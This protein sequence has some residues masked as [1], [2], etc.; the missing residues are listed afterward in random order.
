M[1]VLL[2]QIF[3][4]IFPSEE[5]GMYPPYGAGPASKKKYKLLYQEHRNIR[6][7]SKCSHNSLEIQFS[8]TEHIYITLYILYIRFSHCISAIFVNVLITRSWE[9]GFFITFVFLW[10]TTISPRNA[11]L[12]SSRRCKMVKAYSVV[13]FSLQILLNML[14]D[15]WCAETSFPMK[16]I[17][18]CHLVSTNFVTCSENVQSIF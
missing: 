10:P 5:K 15:S 8:E 13:N 18:Y 12:G 7:S 1:S 2:A 4:R 9:K 16:T 17:S 6:E 14:D 3:S 11:S